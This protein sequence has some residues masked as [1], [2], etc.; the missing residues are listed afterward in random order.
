MRISRL[1]ESHSE[2]EEEIDTFDEDVARLR[3]KKDHMEFDF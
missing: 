3:R 2:N 1:S